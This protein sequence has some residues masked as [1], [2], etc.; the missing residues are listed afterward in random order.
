MS[1]QDDNV[2][3]S[4]FLA[5]VHKYAEVLLV[6]IIRDA[7][8]FVK[9]LGEVTLTPNQLIKVYLHCEEGIQGDL[10]LINIYI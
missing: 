10:L 6:N 4:C 5:N 7:S 3:T 1:Q 8:I 9:V 2:D